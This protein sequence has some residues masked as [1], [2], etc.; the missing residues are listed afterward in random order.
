M[1]LDGS[2]CWRVHGVWVVLS[3]QN[4]ASA[5]VA[6]VAYPAA[7]VGF[8]V[9]MLNHPVL[10]LHDAQEEARNQALNA[11]ICA[12]WLNKAGT[13]RSAGQ[14]RCQTRRVIQGGAIAQTRQY[15]EPVVCSN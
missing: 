13:K 14:Q 2:W 9:M 4:A 15:K 7:L 6:P 11:V 5:S 1:L 12:L 3:V 10:T 8:R